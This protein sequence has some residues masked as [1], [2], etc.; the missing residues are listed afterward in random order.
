MS[1]D[2]RDIERLVYTLQVS[3][4]DIN[5]AVVRA[6]NKTLRTVRNHLARKLRDE[7]RVKLEYIQQRMKIFRANVKDMKGGISVVTRS[8]PATL[9]PF[10]PTSKGVNVNG[11]SYERAWVT[12]K[13]YKKIFQRVGKDRYPI[14]EIRI[15]FHDEYVDILSREV[16]VFEK[17][18]LSN[19]FYELKKIGGL[20]DK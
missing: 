4:Q 18:F 13:G 14:R 12:K 3:G 11:E 8:F 1:L 7:T 6:I 2:Y 20:Y 17:K 9:G 5:K 19:L 15:P 10:Y 16:Q